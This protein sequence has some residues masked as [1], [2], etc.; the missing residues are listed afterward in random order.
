MSGFSVNFRDFDPKRLSTTGAIEAK[1]PDGMATA[2]AIPI[3][4][5]YPVDGDKDVESKLIIECPSFT[6]RNGLQAPKFGSV[7]GK[8]A[9]QVSIK[10]DDPDHQ[11]F[12]GTLGNKHE[13]KTKKGTI[14]RV[15]E[16]YVEPSGVLGSIYDWCVTEYAKF[17]VVADGD[18][19]EDLDIAHYKAASD[20]KTGIQR[21]M[22]YFERLDDD[23][24][25]MKDSNHVKFFKTLSYKP[26]TQE[27]NLAKFYLPDGSRV[28][29]SKLYN[30]GFE[31]TPFLSFR[32]IF[33][34]E[35]IS[36]T[37]EVCEAVITDLLDSH[38]E[39][40]FRSSR[41][42]ERMAKTDPSKAEEVAQKYKSLLSGVD[43]IEGS[44]PSAKKSLGCK[45]DM[46]Q[47]ESEAGASAGA[48]ASKL[49]AI[50]AKDESESEQ[51]MTSSTLKAKP[52]LPD[53]LKQKE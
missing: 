14:E 18:K 23:G 20:P 17:L 7:G 9:F 13:Y 34:G 28:D 38:S 1:T 36:V 16:P 12:A 10:R 26:G 6:S 22:F 52:R 33:I 31:C 21:K 27:E 15:N 11:I 45:I 2:H 53:S 43:T 29:N 35:K 25:I 49:D 44:G 40:S 3:N 19:L 46:L 47:N 41:F 50:K 30:Q 48:K 32:R 42:I 39:V 4:Y 37:M 24:S 51:E 8:P 5:R